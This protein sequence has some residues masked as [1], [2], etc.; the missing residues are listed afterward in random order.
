VVCLDRDWE[1]ISCESAAN[2]PP[3]TTPDN[4]AYVIY[5]SGS[6]GQPKGTMLSHRGLRNLASAQTQVF[7][8]LPSDRILQFSSLSFDASVWE[9]VMALL[10][11]ATLVLATRE[12]LASGQGLLDTLRKQ[13]VTTVTLPPS[14]LAALPEEPLPDL[15]TI[16]A[17][18]EKCPGALAVRWANGRRFFNAYG[19]TETT[20][21]A[22]IFQ[23]V[24]DQRAE[25]SP[26]SQPIGRPI[27]NFQ[28]YVLDARM[29]PTPVGVPGELSIGGVGL[30]RG[31][32]NRPHLTAERFIPHP[33][34]EQ[35]GSRL[36][37]TGDLVRR[38]PDGN[39]EYLGR[40]DH[41]VKVRGFR[42]EL[43]EIEAVLREQSGMRAGIRDVVVLARED[44]PGDGRLVA[45]LITEPGASPNISE[46]RNLLRERLPDYMIPSAFVTLQSFPLTPNGKV[47]RHALPPPERT[48]PELDAGYV[49]PRNDLEQ[50]LADIW[51]KVLGIES[52]GVHDNFFDLGGHSLMLAKAHTQMQEL[53]NRELPMIELFKYPTISA[54]AEYLSRPYEEDGGQT[55]F[56][57]SR[58]RAMEQR[59][60]INF[61]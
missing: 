56:Q 61:G 23:V 45:Y 40:L 50:A 35:A 24:E 20:V 10:H 51:Q 46:L 26:Q 47:D 31:Y 30:A 54:Q 55:S 32:L 28:T 42:I 59:D 2:P 14:M 18:G 52:V 44:A 57:K 34:S 15:H 48:R 58:E 39:L 7:N 53:F 6:T 41:Q 16:I 17:A 21:C 9:V 13:A 11:G 29:Q 5:T 37:K 60:A 43:G 27:A 4:L 33:F 49:T 22:S 3:R 38:L 25:S 8:P 1:A 19:P 12:S 36:Y